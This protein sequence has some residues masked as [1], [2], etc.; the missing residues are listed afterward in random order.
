MRCAA[1]WIRA[2]LASRREL[3]RVMRFLLVAA[4]LAVFLSACGG[5]S[6]SGKHQQV[7]SASPTATAGH[8][9][10]KTG[11][12]KILLDLKGSASDT[13]TKA[14]TAGATW[15]AT[16]TFQC[17]QNDPVYK[18]GVFQI[19]GINPKHPN[20][21]ETV[22]LYALTE[23]RVNKGASDPVSAGRY[24]LRILAEPICSW[25]VVVRTV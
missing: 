15:K 20:G 25:H 10:P 19:Y 22:I 8:P 6:S 1:R 5:S 13:T 23:T 18:H 3:H 16:Y 4:I 17:M 9:Q 11:G 12:G 7:S 2:I 24:K 21:Q 14:F